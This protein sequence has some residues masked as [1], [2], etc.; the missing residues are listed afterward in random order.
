MATDD[1]CNLLANSN[2]T[3]PEGAQTSLFDRTEPCSAVS[4]ETERPSF[5]DVQK[6]FSE[7]DGPGSSSINTFL[8]VQPAPVEAPPKVK[9]GGLLGSSLRYLA[10]MHA[11][12]LGT[13]GATYE[14]FAHNSFF[15]G[16]G[17]SLS[18][19]HGWSDGDGYYENYLGHPIQGAVSAYIWIRHD[20]R[21][22]HVEFGKDPD[23]WKSRLRAYVFA[24]AFSA[25]FEIGPIS[26]A[27]I[28][29][30]QRYC[31]EY[32]F[33]DHVITPNGGMVWLVGEDMLDK[34]VIRRI[35]DHTQ[36]KGLR[37][38]ARVGMNPLQSFANFMSF[39][40]PWHR[41]NRDA[42]SDYR[43]STSTTGY[44]AFRKEVEVNPYD[45]K[46]EFAATVPSVME[47]GGYSCLGGGGIGG[48]RAGKDWQWTLEV[49][50]C[51]LGNSL[52]ETWSGDSLTFNIGP[53][54][55]RHTESRWTP[56]AH[57]R[58]GGQK[59]ALMQTDPV[60]RKKI[61]ESLPPGTKLT[62]YYAVFNKTYESTG[63]AFTMGAGMD[64]R[65]HP[66]LALRMANLEYVHSWL[67]PVAGHDFNNGVRLTTGLVL[68]VGTW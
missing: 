29:Q 45:P 40:Y 6:V 10:V 16:W 9:W 67:N 49:S 47:I 36:N 66:G 30:I 28:G 8:P 52:P 27:T 56:H 44:G 39:T 42:P 26:E 51:T 34:Y 22:Y 25:Q 31:C 54:W 37:I 50:G 46:F 43:P 68:R 13:E 12:R 59:I 60:L 20:P 38:A 64:Y 7:Y 17:A 4:K 62:P 15:G 35:E 5:P 2:C 65:L 41:E 32:G 61:Q 55:I 21:Y 1:L 63:M 24:W 58:F 23:Y 19:M 11:F 57:I 14:A 18:A 53:Q 48:F 33:V 3:N